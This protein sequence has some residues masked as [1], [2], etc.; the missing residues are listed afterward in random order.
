M[1]RESGRDAEQPMT[2]PGLRREI[3]RTDLIALVVN[4]VI[5]A[6]ILGLPAVTYRAL[7]PYSLL[8]WVACAVVMGLATA[9]FAE[10]GSRYRAT[11]GAYLYAYQA[12]GPATGF[13]VGW[14]AWVSRLFSFATILNLAVTYGSGLHPALASDPARLIAIALIASLLTAA[15][16]AGVRR[17][18]TINNALTVIKLL[19][20]GGFVLVGLPAIDTGQFAAASVPRLADW[21]SAIML[22]TFAFLGV[23]STP[24]VSGEMRDPRRDLPIALGVGLS[25]VAL[26]YIAIQAVC[27][28]TVDDLASSERPVI[29]AATQVLGPLGGRVLAAGALVM[30]LGTLFA[31]LITGSRLPYAL[32]EQRQ[33]PACFAACHSRFDTPHIGIIV[34]GILGALLAVYTSFLGALVVTALTRLI[35]YLTT[36]AAL[37][38]LRRDDPPDAR[39]GFVLAAGVP[40]AC[41]TGLACLWLM[42]ASPRAEFMMLLA[43][44]ALGAL[45]GG[46][47]ALLSRSR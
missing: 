7:G 47:Y 19:L 46:V 31:I 41:V 6:G 28:G 15:A 20:L 22:M 5:G 35:G 29:D 10:V 36:C 8:A 33:L 34:T 13:M 11:G 25:I 27:I 26:L 43:L 12:F 40:V 9:C 18:A 37:V 14:L 24:N 32:A 4:V 1:C 17:S 2:T 3:D 38:K 16:I 45:V 44:A 21:Q 39:P 30:M 42:L 23:E